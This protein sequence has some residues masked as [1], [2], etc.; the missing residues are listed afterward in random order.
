MLLDGQVGQEAVGIAFGEF[1]GMRVLVELD[2]PA[3]PVEGGLFRAAG[4]MTDPENLNDAVL[5]PG[6]G[7]VGKQ[8]QRRSALLSGCGHGRSLAR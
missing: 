5:Q 8:A 1:A 7:A 3:N 4:V 2:V 6:R